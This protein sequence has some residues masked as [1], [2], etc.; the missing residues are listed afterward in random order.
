MKLMKK[1]EGIQK[2]CLSIG[3]GTSSHILP[4]NSPVGGLDGHNAMI[5]KEYVN[6][7]SLENSNSLSKTAFCGGDHQTPIAQHVFPSVMDE[8]YHSISTIEVPLRLTRH[9]KRKNPS[10]TLVKKNIFK[11]SNFYET[12]AQD[13]NG[14]GED[15]EC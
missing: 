15:S 2:P 8:V 9:K 3:F 5:H 12:E 13:D 11:L 4:R 6:T 10:T 14:E 7:E 1:F